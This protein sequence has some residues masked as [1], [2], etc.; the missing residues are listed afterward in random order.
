MGHSQR[1]HGGADEPKTVKIKGRVRPVNSE[2]TYYP[3]GKKRSETWKVN[4]VIHREHGPAELYWY[5]DG[6]PLVERWYQNG[7]L[8]REDGPAATTWRNGRV[9]LLEW[10]KHGLLHRDNAPAREHTSNFIRGVFL[11]TMEEWYQ[12]GQL[13]RADGP[14][15]Q[16]WYK[17]RPSGNLW[18]HHGQLHRDGAPAKETWDEKD[19][20]K[21]I[22]W[23]QNGLLHRTGGP[24]LV[25][26]H[27]GKPY[28][29]KWY[30]HGQLH[31][32]GG[33]ADEYYQ[34]NTVRWYKHGQLHRIDGPA[35]VTYWTKMSGPIQISKWFKDGK[36]HR[37][38]GPAVEQWDHRGR[39]EKSEWYKDG[40]LHR[41]DGPARQEWTYGQLTVS[42][43]YR[44]GQL[45]TPGQLRKER[46]LRKVKAVHN[47]SQGAKSLAPG[48]MVWSEA[49]G[50][51][52]KHGYRNP[53]MPRSSCHT[54]NYVDGDGAVVTYS[55]DQLYFIAKGMGLPATRKMNK[56]E[57]CDLMNYRSPRAGEAPF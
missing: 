24:A 1:H 36:L 2:I 53:F 21:T 5:E 33:P 52:I 18:Y 30:F 35:E 11:H 56:S 45:V 47:F 27:D 44:N 22:E 6:S 14:A 46:V 17:D 42:E 23:Y 4:N 25:Y 9:E 7:V 51:S 41:T 12:N 37:D 43:W 39:P 38:D 26:K 28:E 40:Q 31:R 16:S 50:R 54:A 15:M 49:Y 10:F 19:R 57:L 34:G 20:P 48:S 32:D 55:K 3:S 29:T 8:H 13:H